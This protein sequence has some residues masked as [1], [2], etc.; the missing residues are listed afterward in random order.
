[1]VEF[2][3]LR[4]VGLRQVWW[5]EN[6]DFTPWVAEN[7]DLLSGVLEVPLELE[8]RE[9]KVAGHFVD[10]VA[11]IPVNDDPNDNLVIIE[12]QLGWSDHTHLGQ[13]LAYLSGRPAKIAVWVASGFAPNHRMAIRWLNEQTS[14][15]FA[16]FA[17]KIRAMQIG[18]SSPVAADFEIVE[19]PKNWAARVRDIQTAMGGKV[20][21]LN[22]NSARL[23]AFWQQYGQKHPEELAGHAPDFKRTNLYH[24]IIDGIYVCQ[25][26]FVWGVAV[27]LARRG[28]WGSELTPEFSQVLRNTLTLEWRGAAAGG[29]AKEFDTKNPDNWPEMIDWLHDRLEDFRR[30]ILEHARE[31]GLIE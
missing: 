5:R 28:R 16:F 30:V 8:E 12:N 31:T 22:E 21:V 24:K 26:F 25:V 6:S 27:Y 13:I 14:D 19:K 3:E 29:T 17:V 15:D 18:D 4:E 10:I 20:E 2:G 1:M 9:E 7:L 11:R 23:R